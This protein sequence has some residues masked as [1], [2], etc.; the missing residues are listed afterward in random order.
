VSVGL[1]EERGAVTI[2]MASVLAVALVACVGA[3]RLGAGAV[4][5]A[6][7]DA[8]ADAAALAAADSLALGDGAD[9]ALVAARATASANGARLT[10]C[11][12][13]GADAAVDVVVD[14]GVLGTS[15][16]STARAEV[17]G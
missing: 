9:A 7:A 10:R 8:A 17:R 3:A 4:A 12:C 15:A 11:R 6:R 16:K 14:S 13:E 2:V 5:S 1:T